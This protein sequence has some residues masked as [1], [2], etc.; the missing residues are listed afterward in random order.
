METQ[1][2]GHEI[3]FTVDGEDIETT[4][5]KLTPR[6]ILA[7]AELDPDQHYLVRVEDG[8]PVES[9]ETRPNEKIHLRSGIEFASVFTGPTHV[10]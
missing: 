6:E 3:E 9:Y 5:R 8:K 4:Q 2:K 7:L 10:S 1:V